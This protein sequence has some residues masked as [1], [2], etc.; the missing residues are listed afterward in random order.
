MCN[1]ERFIHTVT[2][3]TT[4]A[5]PQFFQPFQQT[6]FG[7][8]QP[9]PFGPFQSTQLPQFPPNAINTQPAPTSTPFSIPTTQ[10]P[11]FLQCT[12]RCLTTNEYN[13]VCGTD[14][15]TYNNPQKLDCANNC[16]RQLNRNW[17]S[18]AHIFPS[19]STSISDISYIPSIYRRRGSC[20]KKLRIRT[21]SLLSHL[22]PGS[23]RNISQSQHHC[24]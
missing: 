10:S 20:D 18:T 9:T 12:S 21:T 3:A 1:N 22:K 4:S 19:Q 17:Q 23:T 13:P 7:P 14:Q 6:Q 5:R 15:I 11:L 2:M 16:G 24:Q 8:F